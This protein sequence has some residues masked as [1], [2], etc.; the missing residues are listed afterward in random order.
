LQ[1][2]RALFF[3]QEKK[4]LPA[5]SRVACLIDGF[6]L[7]HAIDDLRDDTDQRMDYLMWLDLW[8]LAT[9]PSWNACSANAPRPLGVPVSRIS[10]FGSFGNVA[11]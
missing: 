3:V 11:N 5:K 1:T 7:Y 8:S 4:P 9:A 2:R 10:M 6:N